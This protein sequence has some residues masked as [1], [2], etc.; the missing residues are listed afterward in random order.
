[1]SQFRGSKRFVVVAVAVLLIYAAGIASASLVGSLIKIGGVGLLVSKYG[2]EI[3]KGFNKLAKIEEGPTVATKVLPVISVGRG[4]SVGAVQVTGSPQ[5]VEKTQAVIQ[6]EGKILGIQ[7]R[8]L[9]PNDSKNVTKI[10]RV[11]GVG[12][13][14]IVDIKV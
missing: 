2:G 5:Q 11:E 10:N 6:V 3:N 12:V 9:I 14:G 1:M 7:I 8:A 13:S 4:T